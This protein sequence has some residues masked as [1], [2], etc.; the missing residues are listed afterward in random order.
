MS[1]QPIILSASNSTS[2]LL[3]LSSFC[4]SSSD[5]DPSGPTGGRK[6]RVGMLTRELCG[7]A[8][9]AN[10]RDVNDVVVFK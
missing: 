6:E 2:L 9:G 4:R 8:V 10:K 7:D 5:G 1:L 3:L